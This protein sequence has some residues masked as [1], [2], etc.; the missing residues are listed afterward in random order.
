MTDKLSRNF[1]FY[2]IRLTGHLD[3]QWVTWFDGLTIS[4]EENGNTLLSGPVAD[5]SAL[6]G[7]LKKVRD[8]GMPLVSVNQVSLL[9]PTNQPYKEK[10]MNT[11][12]TPTKKIDT[13]VLLSTLWIFLAVNYIYRDILSSMEA[14]TL[15]GYLAGNIGEITIT[16]GFLLAGAIMMEIPFAM[17]VLLQVLKGAANRWAN[18]IAGILMVVIEVGTMGV[19]TLPTMHYLFYS[20]IVIPCNLLIVG[21]AWKWR[22]VEA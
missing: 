9:A 7:L 6:H 12:A 2:E 20:A 14:G 22:N 1:E 4:L 15:Q 18:I 21:C 3:A 13:K 19:G 5:Q 10:R 17:I 16:Q 11:S 8:L